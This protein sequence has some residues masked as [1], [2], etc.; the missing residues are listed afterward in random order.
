[1][2]NSGEG[3]LPDYMKLFFFRATVAKL[4]HGSGRRAEKH[5]EGEDGAT[6]ALNAHFA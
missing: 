3:T 6:S 4:G 1:M 2:C 5:K